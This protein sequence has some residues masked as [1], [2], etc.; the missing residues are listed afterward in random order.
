MLWRV[1]A[2]FAIETVAVVG[3]L[4]GGAGRAAR[5]VLRGSAP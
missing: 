1:P 3:V 2:M 5:T 4:H